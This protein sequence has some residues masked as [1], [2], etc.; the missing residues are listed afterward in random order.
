[1][2]LDLVRR[3]AGRV[4]VTALAAE[5]GRDY[6]TAT[7]N[8]VR[9]FRAVGAGDV[10]GAPDAR[11]E[12]AAALELIA[13]ARLLVLPGGSP[14][15]LLGALRSTGVATAVSALLDDGAVVMGASAGAM[16]LCPWTVLPDRRAVGGPA[17]EAGLGL[18]GDLLVVPHWSGGSSR[19]DW[20]RAIEAVVPA[21]T[22]VL[23]IPEESGVLVE[24]DVLTAVGR[25]ATRLLHEERD[26]QPGDSWDPS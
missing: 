6:D 11:D 19:G 2:D 15:R 16:V 18:V 12:P 10:L 21:T 8:G 9:H 23:G 13:T 1:M 7:A 5:R 25:S 14:T 17:V 22:T 20:L 24:G 3:A 4:V 26:L